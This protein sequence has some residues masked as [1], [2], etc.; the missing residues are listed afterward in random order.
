MQNRREILSRINRCEQVDVPVTNYGVCIS[1]LKGVL[2][3][4]LQPF[5]EALE[6][7]RRIK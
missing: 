1:E 2:E 3:R 7:Y 5:P 4:V 6:A